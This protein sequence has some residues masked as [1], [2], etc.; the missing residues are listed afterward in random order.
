[1][2]P[3]IFTYNTWINGLNH[4]SFKILDGLIAIG[5]TPGTV[6]YSMTLNGLC[7]DLLDQA[8]ILLGKFLKTGFIPDTVT[9]NMLLTCFCKFG[10]GDQAMIWSIQCGNLI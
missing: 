4:Q 10:N 1:M 7:K 3:N 5:F 8:A 6:T 9:Y 2:F